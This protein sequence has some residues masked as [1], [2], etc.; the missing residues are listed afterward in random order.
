M[1]CMSGFSRDGCRNAPSRLKPLI[2][3]TWRPTGAL[4]EG[5]QSRRV[6]RSNPRNACFVAFIAATS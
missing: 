5:L 4:W 3:G 1:S 2:P 6:T